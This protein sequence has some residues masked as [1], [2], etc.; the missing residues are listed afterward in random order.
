MSNST[1]TLQSVVNLCA[2]HADLMPLSNVGGYANEPA[3]S[4][5][6][7]AISEIIT[8]DRDWKWNRNEMAMLV[9]C[10][11]KQDY[12]FGG[13]SAF[14]LGTGSAGAA[15][16]LASNNAITESSTTVTVTTLE[17][18]R[19]SVG[20]TVYMTGNTVAAYNSTF[21][22]DGSQ[23]TWSGGWTITAVPSSTTFQ[24]THASSGL[25]NSGAAGIT[26]FGWLTSA[27]LVEMNSNSSP[28][29]IRHVKAVR[30]ITPWSKVGDPDKVCV[31]KDNGDGTLKIRF[32][33]VPGTTIWGTNLVY[34]AKAPLKASLAETW[35][36]IPDQ[37]SAMVR[38]AL[39]YRMYRYLNSPRA[40]VEYQKLQAEMARMLGADNSE[41]SN[42]YLVPDETLLDLPTYWTGF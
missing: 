12:Q 9:T 11:N 18:H 14:T 22:D 4:L 25:A 13:A 33:Y 2:T 31:L 32:Y 28:Q 3:L 20:Q 23:S 7:D 24:F 39:I 27:S 38:Q 5:C 29:N 41:E 34:Q 26:N 19:F 15:I 21:T 40:E 37:N 42:V 10:P 30:E 36:P 1:L 17:A 16:G 35:S 6:N 8:V